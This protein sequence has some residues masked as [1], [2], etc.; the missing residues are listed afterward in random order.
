MEIENDRIWNVLVL[1]K[2]IK[3]VNN[4]QIVWFFKQQAL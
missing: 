4:Y 1:L 3:N 2:E